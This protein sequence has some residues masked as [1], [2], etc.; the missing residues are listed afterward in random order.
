MLS[1]SKLEDGLLSAM[2]KS[3]EVGPEDGDG[4]VEP[5]YDKADVAGFYA[6][7][8]VAYVKDAEI[9]ML[10]GP[11]M[12]PNPAPP[13]A[14]PFLPDVGAMLQKVAIKTA[15]VGKAALQGA[16]QASFEAGDPAMAIVTAGIIAYT[17]TLTFWQGAYIPLYTATG[18][19]A[20]ALPPIF[21]PVLVGGLAGMGETD[22]AK[23]MAAIIHASFKASIFNGVGTTLLLGVGPVLGQM[24]L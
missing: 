14:P 20:M 4:A 18:V 22:C 24:L 13:P 19:T 2:E 21:I 23:L 7:A 5:K 17:A 6:D 9:M 15:D 10:Y 12:F 11:F 16:F 1:L 8:V 3:R